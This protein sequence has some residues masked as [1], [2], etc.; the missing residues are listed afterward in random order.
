MSRTF[1]CTT[2]PVVTL[3]Q[4]ILIA[5]ALLLCALC[6]ALEVAVTGSNKLFV[7]LE[8]QRGALWTRVLGNALQRPS[9]LMAALL[10]GNTIGLVLFCTALTHALARLIPLPSWHPAGRLAVWWSVAAALFVVTS[11]FLP[12]AL[13]RISPNH[14]LRVLAAP[15]RLIHLVFWLPTKVVTGI[16]TLV[17]RTTGARDRQAHVPLGR[18]D[19]KD[20]VKEVGEAADADGDLSSEVEYFRNTLALS[21]TKARE[22]MVPRAEI[23]A[24][25]VDS[26][27]PLLQSRFVDTG[28]SKLLVY[29]RDIDD[30]IGY[31]HG[32]E[33][34]R[35]PKDIRSVLR[36]VN[37]IAGTMPA[38]QVLQRFIRQRTHVAVVLDEHGGT[39][40][41]LTM[42]DVVET[43]VGDIDDEHDVEEMVEERTGPN[44]FVLSGRVHIAHLV[45]TYRLAVPESDR[46]DTLAGY[47]LHSTGTVPA[48]GA[49]IELPP[50]RITVVHLVHGR[51]DLVRLQVI[52]PAQGF[53]SPDRVEE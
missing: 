30:I 46:Y 44:E 9:Q 10:V 47:I 22:L 27:I 29:R 19:L 53:L 28:L 43:I 26:P 36:P 18:V 14:T 3:S 50:F 23:E 13:A 33:L 35:K 32:Y 40:G 6:A 42:E 5:S 24:V 41:M 12:R 11:E 7:E 17:L 39:A 48:A 1:G 37:R 4:A 31:V 49:V 52:D 15:L 25:Q 8:R 45:A 21:D 38:D 51:I 20:L 2:L 16:G 34:F